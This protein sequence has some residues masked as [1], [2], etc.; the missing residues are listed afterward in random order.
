VYDE[1]WLRANG[2]EGVLDAEAEAGA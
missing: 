1:D 2:L